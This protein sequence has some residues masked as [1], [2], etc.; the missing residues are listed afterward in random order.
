MAGVP[1]SYDELIREDRVHGRL[2]YDPA[3]FEEEMEKIF[4][5][6][7][8]YV[9]HASEIPKPGDFRTKWIGRQP[10]IMSR[11]DAGEIHLLMNRCRHRANTV[12]QEEQGNASFFRCDYHGWTYSNKGD[13]VG[14]T[15]ARVSGYDEAFRKEELG[16]SKVPRIGV[17]RG[18]IFGSLSPSGIGFDEYLGA[19]KNYLDQFVELAPAGEI[20][21]QAGVQKS[22]VKANWKMQLENLVDHYHTFFVHQS[23]IV[24]Q[25][26][27]GKDQIEADYVMRDLGGGHTTLDKLRLQAVAMGPVRRGG[28]DGTHDPRILEGLKKR[29]GEERAAEVLRRGPPHIMI[30][31]N[32]MV[33][34]NAV[35]ALH[36]VSV[37]ETYL[38]YYP[39]LLKGAPN[40]VN[41]RRIK[42]HQRGHGP[43][44]S[45]SAD[46]REIFMR[47]Q[48]A[49][50]ARVDEWVLLRR[51]L[52]EER[53]E[54]DAW[55]VPVRTVN[56]LGELTQRAIWGHY[57][58]IMT[59]P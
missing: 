54:P 21:L 11:D 9:G 8:V 46:D 30:F 47:N 3:I 16:L 40:E 33:L 25:T 41:A 12:C 31:P 50:E 27:A 4:H 32:L 42:A 23:G 24:R 37:K 17:H 53:V 39:A 19:A 14:V 38:H 49:L 5:R 20:E 35:R 18:F 58:K 44:G 43:A 1:I 59:Q 57:K 36:P 34:Q 28:D 13:L 15:Y 7:W 52:G 29:L 6:G 10:V 2:Y 51:A 48:A 22:R 45:V 26:S 55:G 56:G